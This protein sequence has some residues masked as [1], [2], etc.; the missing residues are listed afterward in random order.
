MARINLSKEEP[1]ELQIEQA[2]KNVTT[3][4]MQSMVK[5]ALWVTFRKYWLV[6]TLFGII[7]E[8]TGV[9][10]CYFITYLISY[11]RDENA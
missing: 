7:G 11:L 5:K 9:F 10:T 1:T 8:C 6:A 3:G 2:L 4:E